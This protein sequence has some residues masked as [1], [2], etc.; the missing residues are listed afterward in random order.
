MI[1]AKQQSN[2]TPH[3]EGQFAAVCCDVVDLGLKKSEWGGKTTM[4]HKVRV[5][6]QSTEIIRTDDGREFPATVSQMFTLSLSEKGNLRPFLESWIGKKLSKESLNN[7]VDLE[8]LIGFPALV[9]VAHSEDGQYANVMSISPLPAAMKQMAPRISD[10]YVRVKDR[11]PKEGQPAASQNAAPK[12]AENP[13]ITD[14]LNQGGRPSAP[15]SV[16]EGFDDFPATLEDQ[17][18]D[19]P[20]N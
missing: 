1:V 7:G 17:D 14:V 13:R 20:F 5:V 18:D 12:V 19:L 2:F 3:P 4:K 10:K 8:Q 11:E 6:F 9:T 16:Q 15:P